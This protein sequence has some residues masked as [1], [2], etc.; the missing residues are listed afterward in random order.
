MSLRLPRSD[1]LA[2]EIR[3]IHL[4]RKSQVHPTPAPEE[5]MRSSGRA[6]A[7]TAR[8]PPY[9]V[10]RLLDSP[11]TALLDSWLGRFQATSGPSLF[12]LA[13]SLAVLRQAVLDRLRSV[14]A[15]QPAEG[16]AVPLALH[17]A[18][19]SCRHDVFVSRP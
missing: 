15:G 3:D 10:P 1:R 11:P 17:E 12:H 14:L 6:D 13:A 16:V 5:A 2:L 7:A 19:P 9:P 8:P 18:K 4:H